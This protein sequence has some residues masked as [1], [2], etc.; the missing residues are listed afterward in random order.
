MVNLIDETE[1][2]KHDVNIPHLMVLICYE[3]TLYPIQ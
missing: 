2:E 1:A 3:F